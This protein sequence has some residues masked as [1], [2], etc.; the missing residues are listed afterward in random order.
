MAMSEAGHELCAFKMYC[1]SEKKK[2]LKPNSFFSLW[3]DKV[4]ENVVRKSHGSGHL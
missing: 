1:N 3:C 4:F 2:K